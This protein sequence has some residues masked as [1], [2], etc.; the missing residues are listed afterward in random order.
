MHKL[1]ISPKAYM[2]FE[3]IFAYTIKHWSYDQAL[4]YTAI[5]DG[6]INE[7]ASGKIEGKNYLH[8]SKIYKI[9][10]SGKHLIFYRI[11]INTCIIVR[12]LHE[13]MDIDSVL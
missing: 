13:K 10:K 9:V 3:N 6:C 8:T 2:D 12:I 1:S 5:I 7:I 11:E 4:K